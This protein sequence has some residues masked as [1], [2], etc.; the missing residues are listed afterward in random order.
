MPRRLVVAAWPSPTPPPRPHSTRTAGRISCLASCE[1]RGSGRMSSRSSSHTATATPAEAAKRAPRVMLL[2]GLVA[3]VVAE[4]V[5]LLSVVE[6]ASRK[7]EREGGAGVRRLRSPVASSL[8]SSKSTANVCH[9]Q[10][11]P[12]RHAVVVP[13]RDTAC[14][15]T[16]TKCWCRV[17]R[18]SAAH[19]ADRAQWVDQRATRAVCQRAEKV[20]TN[21]TT[22]HSLFLRLQRHA[23]ARASTSIA[24]SSS[25]RG[26]GGQ[27]APCPG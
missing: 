13:T 9:G 7:Q 18:A 16:A 26:R 23:L 24:F 8:S 20:Y 2:A 15:C 25:P 5:P 3:P 22:L 11:S 19:G 6:R 17:A 14:P 12:N 1:M 10:I 21:F 27:P 4:S